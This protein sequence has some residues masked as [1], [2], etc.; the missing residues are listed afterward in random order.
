[1][2][3]LCSLGKTWYYDLLSEN[4]IFSTSKGVAVAIQP[5]NSIRKVMLKN[6]KQAVGKQREE[7]M[8]KSKEMSF[9][10]LINRKTMCKFTLSCSLY[11]SASYT[12]THT[13]GNYCGKYRKLSRTEENARANRHLIAIPQ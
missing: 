13:G 5:H 2:V 1:M 11:S 9:T 10:S 6:T 12:C 8:K 3:I 4:N 7:N